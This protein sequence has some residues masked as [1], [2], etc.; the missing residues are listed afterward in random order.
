MRRLVRIFY[1]FQQTKSAYTVVGENALPVYRRQKHLVNERGQRRRARLVKADRKVTGMKITTH[2]NSGMQNSISEH[3]RKELPISLCPEWPIV[4]HLLSS[5]KMPPREDAYLLTAM[6]R[7]VI[8]SLSTVCCTLL[9][10]TCC[11]LY[12]IMKNISRIFGGNVWYFVPLTFPSMLK[13]WHVLFEKVKSWA[14]II[15]SFLRASFSC[16]MSSMS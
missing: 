8:Y 2:Y 16:F 13:Y 9:F 12:R 6:L 7:L 15:F 3:T 4:A 14:A 5:G 10:V 11:A 1:V